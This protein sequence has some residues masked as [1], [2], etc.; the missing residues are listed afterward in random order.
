M[1]TKAHKIVQTNA[2]KFMRA[3]K[4]IMTIESKK[5][6]KHFT[7]RFKTPKNIDENTPVK[8]I[9]I[10]VSV[11]TGP[12]NESSYAFIG[13]IFGNKYYHSK[14]TN[15]S[16]DALSVVAF[17]YWFNALVTNN[18][19]RLNQIELYHSGK[20][21]R[22]GRTL[23]TPE[24]IELGVGPICGAEIDRLELKRTKQI[25]QTLEISGVDESLIN[26]ENINTLKSFM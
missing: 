17:K 5:T 1:N 23:T 9:P 14:K 6:Q 8:D 12:D 22:C 18:Q 26:N 3:G 21:M 4:A 15:I 13:T 24:S 25:R 2:L 20:C 19:K 7:F 16:Q 10:W 11:L